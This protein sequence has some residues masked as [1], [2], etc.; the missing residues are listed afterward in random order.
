MLFRDCNFERWNMIV[1][2][3]LQYYSVIIVGNVL[4]YNKILWHNV[5]IYNN[6]LVVSSLNVI[7][8]YLHIHQNGQMLQWNRSTF[9]TKTSLTV[10]KLSTLV[11]K[12]ICSTH[13]LK[14]TRIY[15]TK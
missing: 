2:F 11:W 7:T 13:I 3:N 1:K 15:E 14:I 10:C 4:M 6:L 8:K 12:L 5:I 9:G